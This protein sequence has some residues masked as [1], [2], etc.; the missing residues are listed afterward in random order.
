MLEYAI[1]CQMHLEWMMSH[2]AFKFFGSLPALNFFVSLPA[3]HGSRSI[4]HFENVLILNLHFSSNKI[5][6]LWCHLFFSFGLIIF[7]LSTKLPNF[8]PL[9]SLYLVWWILAPS[10]GHLLC[11]SSF[12]LCEITAI[13]T[14]NHLYC[15]V[16]LVNLVEQQFIVLALWHNSIWI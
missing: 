8:L 9:F 10:P 2:E 4:F 14:E 6:C 7:F 5:H 16:V 13:I 12:F 3:Y 15:W 11:H 1:C